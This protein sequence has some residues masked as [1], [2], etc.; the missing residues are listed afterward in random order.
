MTAL[1]LAWILIVVV[2]SL[3]SY[4]SM[5]LVVMAVRRCMVCSSGQVASSQARQAEEPARW[6]ALDDQQVARYLKQA[7]P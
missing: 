6:T 5:A 3:A 1:L 2:A 4:V 7:P